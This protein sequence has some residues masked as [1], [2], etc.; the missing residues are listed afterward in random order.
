MGEFLDAA[1]ADAAAAAADRQP[2]AGR[3]WGDTPTHPRFDA[4]TAA[5]PTH[6]GFDAA[7]ATTPD[8][9][10]S[11][12][13]RRHSRSP[14]YQR[15]HE[16]P[17]SPTAVLLPVLPPALPRATAVTDRRPP[18]AVPTETVRVRRFCDVHEGQEHV[19]V[20]FQHLPCYKIPTPVPNQE[21]VRIDR[22]H[23]DPIYLC[24]TK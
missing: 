18:P 13:A 22:L 24:G 2:N 17:P 19:S 8:R 20:A 6:L 1:A 7:I 12:S 21:T 23:N 11:S 3:Q 5:T 10:L 15:Y 9:R 14:Y 16:P 4:T